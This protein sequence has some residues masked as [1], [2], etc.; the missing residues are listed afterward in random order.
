MDEFIEQQSE[1]M[2][3]QALDEYPLA[4]LPPHFVRQVMV[5]VARLP[6]WQPEPFRLHWRDTV[7]PAL[8]TV[9]VYLLLSLSLWLFGRDVAWLPPTPALFSMNVDSLATVGW[10]SVAIMILVGEIGL[11][12]WVGVSLWWDQPF[13]MKS[14]P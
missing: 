13:M 9:F 6:Q 12:M 1:T 7:V 2:V 10:L 3:E 8:M 11:L 5:R 4:P 14:E